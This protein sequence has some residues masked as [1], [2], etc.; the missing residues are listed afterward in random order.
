MFPIREQWPSIGLYSWVTG[1]AVRSMFEGLPL[2]EASMNLEVALQSRAVN[3]PHQDPGDRFLAATALVF[4]LTLVTA[5]KRMLT[6]PDLS[7][8]DAAS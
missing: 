4:E 8:M 1:A 7:L 6:A 3:L 5:D 2:K